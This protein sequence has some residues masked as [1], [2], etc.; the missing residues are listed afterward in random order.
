MALIV[1]A[2]GGGGPTASASPSGPASTATPTP[3][4]TPTATPAASPTQDADLPAGL[5]PSPIA[6]V[7]GRVSD[8]QSFLLVADP[9]G[10][11]TPTPVT[12]VLSGEVAARPG[13]DEVALPV[14]ICEVIDEPCGTIIVAVD[15]ATRAERRLTPYSSGASDA[16]PAWSPDGSHLVFASS[17]KGDAFGQELYVVPAAGGDAV[18]LETGFRTSQTPAWSPDGGT[19]AFVGVDEESR[20]GLYLVDA[21]G[22]Q[23]RKLIDLDGSTPLS[24]SPDGTRIAYQVTNNV[25]A[26]TDELTAVAAIATVS[27]ADG[28]STSVRATPSSSRSPAWS[29]DGTAIAFILEEEGLPSRLALMGPDGQDVRVLGARDWNDL[30]FTWLQ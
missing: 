6:L 17:R 10:A 24:W 21:G 27:V 30:G 4:A 18:L 26:G 20:S 12:G 1:A 9:S 13:S 7:A 14:T 8:G 28:V 22:G 23:P 15:L 5:P 11:R 29:P 2:C 16:M 19:I 3:A 25:Q